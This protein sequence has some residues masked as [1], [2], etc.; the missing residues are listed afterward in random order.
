MP[1]NPTWTDAD[2]VTLRDYLAKNPRFLAEFARRKP[3]MTKTETL[4]AR[5]V[6]GSARAGYE[7]GLGAINDMAYGA[8]DDREPSPFIGA[9]PQE[10]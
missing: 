6:S 2:A 9:Q 8:T 7:D 10:E 5:A 4:E 3:P 1:D